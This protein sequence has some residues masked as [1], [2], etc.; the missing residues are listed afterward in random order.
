MS[1]DAC[2]EIAW[3]TESLLA[4]EIELRRLRQRAQEQK[5]P[6]FTDMGVQVRTCAIH[7]YP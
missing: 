1:R 3:L 2:H 6:S 4:S 5:R 7:A